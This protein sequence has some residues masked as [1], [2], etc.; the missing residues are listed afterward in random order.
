M[1]DSIISANQLRIICRAIFETLLLGTFG[2]GALLLRKAIR[3]RGENFNAIRVPCLKV[4]AFEGVAMFV[5]R[6]KA[7]G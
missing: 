3:V 7:F 6:E 1:D 2:M 5:I 4:F